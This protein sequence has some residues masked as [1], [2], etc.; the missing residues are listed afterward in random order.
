MMIL[1]GLRSE[2][3]RTPAWTDR[4]LWKGDILRQ[5]QY[6]SALLRCSDHRPV[7][8]VFDCEITLIDEPKKTAMCREIYERL[9]PNQAIHEPDLLDF[10][11]DDVKFGS[12]P[13]NI[14]R[15]DTDN[16]TL[17]TQLLLICNNLQVADALFFFFF[18]FL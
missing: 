8:A 9:R 12:S 3:A 6:M 7:F 4:I 16:G 2:Q 1:T 13:Q 10:S 15:S 17:F 18:F 11:G 14:P 5:L